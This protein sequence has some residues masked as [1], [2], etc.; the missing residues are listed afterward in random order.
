MTK[1]TAGQTEV[2]SAKFASLRRYNVIAAVIHAAQAVAVV[3]LAN[4]FSI[5]VTG[6][7]LIGPPGSPG[8]TVAIFDVRVGLAVAAF[9]ALSA[10]FHVIVS[11][12]GAFERYRDGLKRQINVFRWV[13]YA[14]SSSLMIV[15]IA[16][17]CGITDV[18]AL[19]GLAGVNAA[20]ILFGWL[21][22]KYH[23]PG[24]GKW[25]PFLFGCIAGVIPWLAIVV[26]VA[27]PGST[28]GAQ[29]PTFVYAIIISLFIFFNTFAV[30]QFLQY[31]PVGKFRNYL[32]GERAYITL[33]LVA[34]SLLAWQVFAGTL[35]S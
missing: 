25:L 2:A 21:Q 19:L 23:Q 15:L 17:I 5:P 33:S 34:K 30:N 14:L 22:E 27:A 20:M 31:K 32:V 26:Y 18:A 1:S 4:G 29:P 10:I 12:P 9:L 3:V 16:M 7:Y 13:E 8:E 35:A 11:M 24:D 6:T 28:S